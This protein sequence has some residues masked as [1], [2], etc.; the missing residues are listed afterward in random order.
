MIEYMPYFWLAVIVFMAIC[1]FI[2]TQLV[3]I[4]FVIGAICALV[5]SLIT[6]NVFVQAGVFLVVTL[7]T[8][9]ATR[10]IVKKM[11]GFQKTETNS[12]RVIGKTA[13]VILEVNNML[14][15][16]QV[17]VEGAVWSARSDNGEVLEVG[18]KVRILRIEG[19]KLIVEKEA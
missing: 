14:G 5:T 17:N 11:K 8:L 1:E 19:V 6:D 9:I 16:G 7:V 15:Q 18:T 13:D 10:P 4:W 2:T 3:S 12:D